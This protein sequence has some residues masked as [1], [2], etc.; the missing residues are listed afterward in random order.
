M[1]RSIL[2]RV[3]EKQEPSI[4]VDM[5]N[6]ILS[7]DS[8][9]AEVIKNLNMKSLVY[10]PILNERESLGV[11][12]VGGSSKVQR[13]FSEGNI[14]LLTAV[15]SQTALSIAHAR[16]FQKLQVC[17]LFPGT[18]TLWLLQVQFAWIQILKYSSQT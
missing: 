3:F 15:A 14:N 18:D 9:S 12:L 17:H 2:Q 1:S 6:I 5:G 16:S 4:I 13:E 8:K 10:V 11:M 7:V